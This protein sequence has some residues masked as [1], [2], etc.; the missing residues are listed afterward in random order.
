MPTMIISII[1]TWV[2]TLP[3]AYFLPKY[4]D[5]GVM[6][7]RWAMSL[8]PVAAGIANIIYFRTGKWKTRRV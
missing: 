2:I 6:G 7:I 8:S 4:T 1:T 5:S 3:L